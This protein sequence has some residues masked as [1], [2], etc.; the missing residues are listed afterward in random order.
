[1]KGNFIISHKLNGENYQTS[2]SGTIRVTNCQTIGSTDVISKSWGLY[3]LFCKTTGTI[4]A[5]YSYNDY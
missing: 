3:V 5:F 1:M 2:T 4:R